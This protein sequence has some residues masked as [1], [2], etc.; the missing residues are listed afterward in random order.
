M[1]FYTG[2]LGTVSTSEDWTF[3]FDVVDENGTDVVISSA[4]ITVAIRARGDTTP[5]LTKTVGSG[6]TVATP[7]F[8]VL[9]P[10][11]DMSGL[12]PGQYDVGCT[13]EIAGTKSQLFICTVTVVDGIVS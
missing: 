10:D 11:T 5:V 7:T 1:A 3:A 6:I 12:C 2:S 9:V 4:S 8:T 13:V